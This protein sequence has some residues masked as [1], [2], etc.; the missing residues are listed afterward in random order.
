MSDE[1]DKDGLINP[2]VNRENYKR[3]QELE[4]A[5][6]LGAIPALVDEE[7]RDINP[8]IPQYITNVPFFYGNTGPT[9]KH[10][11]QQDDRVPQHDDIHRQVKRGVKKGSGST[12]YKKGA[13]ENCGSTTHKK[14]DCVE[15]PRRVGARFNN[16]NI[17]A[18]EYIPTE[19]NHS[20][21]GKRDRWQDYDPAEH[22]EVVREFE[23]IEAEKRKLKLQELKQRAAEARERAAAGEE[24]VSAE[25]RVD[26][27]AEEAS[28]DSDDDDDDDKDKADDLRY[29]E[30]ANMA[31]AKIDTK[32]RISV[33]NLRIREDTAKYLLNLDVNSAHY[34]P[35]TR[36][37]RAD[38]LRGTNKKATKAFAG[39]NFVRHTGEVPHIAD[40]QLFAWDAA[41]KGV[42]R[43]LVLI[44]AG[45]RCSHGKHC[46]LILL[47]LVVVVSPLRLSSCPL[48]VSRFENAH[49]LSIA[50]I[51]QGASHSRPPL[52][53]VMAGVDVHLQADPTKAE[54][55]HKAFE[56]K[57][58]QFGEQQ[59]QSILEKY[60]GAEHLKAPPKELLMAQTEHYVEYSQSG[61]VIKG[62][63]KAKV[64]SKYEEDVYPGNHTSVWGSYWS[65][66]RWGYACCH[67]TEKQSYCT[68]AEGRAARAADP[69]QLLKLRGQAAEQAQGEGEEAADGKPVET[70][71]EQHRKSNK[72]KRSK[73][74]AAAEDDDDEAREKRIKEYM[75][76][77]RKQERE[78]DRLMSM[79]ERSRPFNSMKE[80]EHKMSE[81]EMEAYHRTRVHADD[82]MAAFMK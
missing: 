53:G 7:G 22:L 48:L 40:R 44:P 31:G 67:A 3:R 6:K 72:G 2:R 35:K 32:N 80:S 64:Q 20:F 55:L 4:E 39:E 27:K 65:R 34:D 37:M 82:P 66:G 26:P 60:G 69:T 68:G 79:D 70:L 81:E 49:R 19:L 41:D 8:H 12:R 73:D 46:A 30:S 56:Q 17:A 52:L 51:D 9:L 23:K 58:Q 21:E 42:Y 74:E 77:H 59:R 38:P 25:K 54:M 29:A 61:R 43:A 1:K 62:N 71:L 14:Q 50:Y 76:K 11:R 5:R 15:R 47:L 33:R 10:Q 13:C 78:A 28:D 36:A 63:E 16:K 24:D 45:P 57:K 18:D 75:E